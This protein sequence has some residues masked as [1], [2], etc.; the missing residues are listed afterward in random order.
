MK[1][2]R[3]VLL[4]RFWETALGFWRKGGGRHAWIMTIGV[5]SIALLNIAL[6]YR[7]NVWHRAMF[8]ALDKRDGAVVVHQSMIFFPLILISVLLAASATYA[9]M[10]TQR[11]WRQWLNAHILDRWLSKGRHYQLNLIPGDHENPE[12]RVT[13]D[14]RMACDAPVEFVTGILSAIVTA[15]TFISVLWFIGGA[16]TVHIGGS[17]L[18]IPGFLVIAA[19]IYAVLASGSM[20]VI[21]NSFVSVSER[22]N[23]AE[24]EYRY[25]LTRFR[26]NGESIALLGGE[27]EERSGLDAAFGKV[28]ARWRDIMMQYVRTTIVST[29]SGG[30]APVVPILLCAPKYVAGT[31]SLGEVMQAASAFV[32]VQTAFSWLVDNYP[33]LADWSASAAR[34]SSLLVAF[35]RLERAEGENAAG[36][37]TRRPSEDASIRLRDVSVTLADGNVVINEADIAIAGGERVLFAGASGTGKSTLIRAIAGLWPWGSGEIVIR[38]EGLFLLPQLPYVPLGTLRRALTYPLAPDTVDDALLRK[39]TEEVGLGHFL[40]RLDEDDKWESILS[41]GEKQRLAFARLLVQKPTVIIMDEAT[42]AL[43]PPSQDELMKLLLERLPEATILSV[44]HRA[45]LD[46]F[47]TRKLVLEYHPEGAML[48][49]D[50]SLAFAF[51]RSARFLARLLGAEPAPTR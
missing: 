51:R 4:A 30:I 12:H 10:T 18:T 27:E 22:K 45:E 6:Q 50:E 35:D 29:T 41:G 14:L 31:M 38:F 39:T 32:I 11:Q 21:A 33:R 13:E 23:Q 47:H 24:A 16:L 25:A 8:D 43:D 48:E 44:G 40:D 34:L 7:I 42:S 49:S 5:I 1:Q 36:H 15:L 46:A 17:E 20:M 9:K 28:V 2:S 3:Q 19:V 26:E 37:I